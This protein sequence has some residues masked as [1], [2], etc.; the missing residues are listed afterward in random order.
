MNKG[1]AFGFLLILLVLILGFYVAYTGFVSGRETLRVQRPPEGEAQE[2]ETTSVSSTRVV[3]EITPAQ[4]VTPTG[5]PDQGQAPA[6]GLT[7]TLTITP[8]VQLVESPTT[9]T[10]QPPAAPTPQPTHTAV[11]PSQP[12]TT[13]TSPTSDSGT[14]PAQPPTPVAVLAYQYR[15]AGPPSANPDYPICC[16][17]YGTVQDA[18]GNGLEG[19]SVQVANEWNPPIV[20]VTKGGDETGK[21]DIPINASVVNWEIALVDVAGTQIS[22]KVQIQFNADAENG[23]RVDWQRTY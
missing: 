17:I 13:P 11:P 19:I 2:A 12:V 7:T 1:Y 16:Y 9:P 5:L 22:T 8:A 10:I 6:E 20:A 14:P 21:Y 23:Y 18:D 4:N 3:L 15:L